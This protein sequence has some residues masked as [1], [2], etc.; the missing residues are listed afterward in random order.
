MPWSR[1]MHACRRKESDRIW[2]MLVGN[3]CAARVEDCSLHPK[4]R[5]YFR[6][7]DSEHLNLLPSEKTC[8]NR[9][10]T[11]CSMYATMILRIVMR[12]RA[13]P[14]SRRDSKSLLILLQM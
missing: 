3:F 4:A 13:T 9:L 14:L 10:G 11:S 7:N 6:T 8:S 1:M 12:L 5:R 2:S